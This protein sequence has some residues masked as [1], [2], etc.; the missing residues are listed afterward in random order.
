MKPRGAPVRLAD[1]AERAPRSVLHRDLKPS[2]LLL[3]ANCDL[4][5]GFATMGNGDVLIVNADL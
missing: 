3:N 1:L 5:V 4:K 2:N